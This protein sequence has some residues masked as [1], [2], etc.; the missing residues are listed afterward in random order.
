MKSFSKPFGHKEEDAQ[1]ASTAGIAQEKV[2]T[3]RPWPLCPGRMEAARQWCSSSELGTSMWHQPPTDDT[4]KYKDA[5]NTDNSH[6]YDFSLE[7]LCFSTVSSS[8]DN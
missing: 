3:W 5:S 7:L 6:Y 8:N 4:D 2:P 1:L